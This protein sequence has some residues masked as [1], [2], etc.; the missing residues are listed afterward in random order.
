MMTYSD[1]ETCIV[2][3]ENSLFSTNVTVYMAFLPI[4]PV[5]QYKYTN[6]SRFYLLYS[7][8]DFKSSEFE[9]IHMDTL[10]RKSKKC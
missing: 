8:E 1:M 4:S 6:F 10:D 9:L 2:L 3:N 5:K 7:I